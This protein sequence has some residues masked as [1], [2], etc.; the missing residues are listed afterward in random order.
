MLA[1]PNQTHVT[2]GCEAHKRER[3]G[4]RAEN[5]SAARHTLPGPSRCPRQGWRH[6][7]LHSHTV[8]LLR[9][10]L[11]PFSAPFP[12]CLHTHDGRLLSMSLTARDLSWFLK[13]NCT[14]AEAGSLEALPRQGRAPCSLR[15]ELSSWAASRAVTCT[16]TRGQQ[17]QASSLKCCQIYGHFMK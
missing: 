3:I 11:P 12:L 6:L 17:E 2:G 8:A 10:E 5:G 13:G 7:S 4:S 1:G 14:E 15:T 16:A 9:L